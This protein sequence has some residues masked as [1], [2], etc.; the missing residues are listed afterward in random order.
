MRYRVSFMGL[1]C[2][3]FH[4]IRIVAVLEHKREQECNHQC[5]ACKSEPD[6]MPVPYAIVREELVY[7]DTAD[8]PSEESAKTIRHHHK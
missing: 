8:Q 3:I 2:D 5:I 7:Y 4:I 1:M 6:V